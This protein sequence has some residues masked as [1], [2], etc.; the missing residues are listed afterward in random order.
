MGVSR[1]AYVLQKRG[2]EDVGNLWFIEAD[3]PSEG[4]TDSA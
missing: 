4:C 1:A 3:L 2:I